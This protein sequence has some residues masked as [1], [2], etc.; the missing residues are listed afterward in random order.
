MKITPD[1]YYSTEANRYYWSVSQFKRFYNC[2]AQGLAE[3][4]GEYERE[5]TPSLL[6]GSYIDSYF[7]GDLTDFIEKHPYIFNS[8]TG[9][10]KADYKKADEIISRLERDPFFMGYL[11]GE[12]QAIFTADLFGLPWKAKLDIYNGQRIVDLKIVKDFERI[13]EE[14]YGRRSWIEFWGYDVQGAI[15]QRIVEEN[16]GEKLPF[17]LAV[18]TKEKTTNYNV[19]QIAQHKLDEAYHK[20]EAYIERFDLIKNGLVPPRRCEKCDY[21]KNTRV[22]TNVTVYDGEGGLNV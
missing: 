6:V 16:T 18:A 5:E 7:S 8:R 10:L 14:G 4:N 13:Y 9:E 1:N 17:Y 20:V 15:Y 19:I 3:I 11:E 21:C 22:L 12:K 2:E